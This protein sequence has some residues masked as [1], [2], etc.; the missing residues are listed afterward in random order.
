MTT[1]S[2]VLAVAL[3]LAG[4]AHAADVDFLQGAEHD[5]ACAEALD[6]LKSAMVAPNSVKHVNCRTVMRF[7]RK[8]GRIAVEG[9]MAVDITV[10]A[11][12]IFGAM[13]EGTFLV[14]IT[15]A[16]ER[17]RIQVGEPSDLTLLRGLP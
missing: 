3:A 17:G 6:T 9:Q 7:N 12:N 11:Q 13:I 15:K 4:T 10:E 14:T 8:G 5:A 16:G 2:G 1:L